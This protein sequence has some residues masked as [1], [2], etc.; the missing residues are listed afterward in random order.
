MSSSS[1]LSAE[2]QTDMCVLCVP[3][4]GTRAT[5]NT[6]LNNCRGGSF[7]GG[8]HPCMGYNKREIVRNSNVSITMASSSQPLP[9]QF[10]LLALR[11][12]RRPV[13]LILQRR[14]R[15]RRRCGG[16]RRS[17]RTPAAQAACIQGQL[18]GV[19]KRGADS[20]PPG[21]GARVR[22]GNTPSPRQRFRGFR[23]AF[24]CDFKICKFCR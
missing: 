12:F 15:K 20:L 8:V 10:F 23:R 13:P 6:P 1:L 11:L 3:T 2:G 7:L 4:L 21:R 17:C 9:A 24:S 19:Q 22:P 18:Q 5:N 16:A 14:F